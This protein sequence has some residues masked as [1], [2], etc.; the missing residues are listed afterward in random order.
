VKK[1]FLSAEKKKGSI[2]GRYV[3]SSDQGCDTSTSDK[4]ILGDEDVAMSDKSSQKQSP[5]PELCQ[6]GVRILKRT[7]YALHV[8]SNDRLNSYASYR[9]P[10]KKVALA[11]NNV[12]N[13]CF[14]N[15]VMQCLMHTIPLFNFLTQSEVHRM[16]L[17]MEPICL[18]CRMITYAKKVDQGAITNDDVGQLLELMPKYMPGFEFGIQQD[19]GE[20]LLTILSAIIESQFRFPVVVDYTFVKMHSNS[21]PLGKVFE[22]FTNNQKQCLHCRRSGHSSE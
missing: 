16:T 11:M 4:P 21:T 20:C 10:T 9:P 1:K 22:G 17:C 14:F 15:S 5:P 7:Q 8:I 6:E 18:T 19:A 13:T 12:G 2:L 3:S